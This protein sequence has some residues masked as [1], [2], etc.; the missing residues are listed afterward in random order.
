LVNK[1]SP[2]STGAQADFDFYP[3]NINIGKLFIGIRMTGNVTC[4]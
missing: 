3:R 1:E 4:Q 2:W